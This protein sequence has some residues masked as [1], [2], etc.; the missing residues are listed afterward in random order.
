M[1]QK[2]VLSGVSGRPLRPGPAGQG[3]YQS[4]CQT[5]ASAGIENSKSQ[6]MT[7]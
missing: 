4:D 5:T 1:Q 3:L 6:S 2:N 7:R